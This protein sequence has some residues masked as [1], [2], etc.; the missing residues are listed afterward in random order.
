MEKMKWNEPGRQDLRRGSSRQKDKN[1]WL[2]FWPAPDF[3]WRTFISYGLSKGVTFISV[4]AASHRLDKDDDDCDDDDD[5]G[6]KYQL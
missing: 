1:A 3:K 4:S 6:I 5:D 2:L